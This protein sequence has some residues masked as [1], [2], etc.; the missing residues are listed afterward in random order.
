[1]VEKQE[2]NEKKSY[3]RREQS[4]SFTNGSWKVQTEKKHNPVQFASN[5][6]WNLGTHL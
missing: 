6:L 3:K 2:K 5:R 1:M 4:P